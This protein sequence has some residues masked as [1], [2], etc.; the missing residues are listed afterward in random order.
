MISYVQLFPTLRCNKNCDFCFN[1][2]VNFGKLDKEKII[3]L[4][5]VFK[6]N[7]IKNLDILG[8]EPFLYDSLNILIEKALENSMEITISSN[9]S[10]PGKIDKFM[11][12]YCEEK[13]K[14]G[15]SINS[16]ASE[17][18]LNLI[19]KYKLLIKTVVTRGF[20]I[21]EKILNFLK[22]NEISYYLIY[23]DAIYKED[24]KRTMPFYEFID[25]IELQKLKYKK[26]SPVF[27]KGFIDSKKS[28]R[29]P[30]GTEKITIMPDGSVFPCYLFSRFKEFCLGNIFFSSLEEILNS[31]KLEFFKKFEGNKCVKKCKI[32]KICHGGCPAISFIHS[33]S[34]DGNDPRCFC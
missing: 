25:F 16:F 3:L 1:R 33:G 21:S 23:M 13:I 12:N 31:S 18:L 2:G 27:C 24:L 9:G 6:E 22:F 7:N 28:Y 20:C 26:I 4:I 19:A 32:H 5:D 29:C 14:V 30:A 11:K 10:F 34:L 8:G 15:I 17:R